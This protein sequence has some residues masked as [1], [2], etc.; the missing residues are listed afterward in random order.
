MKVKRLEREPAEMGLPPDVK[1]V[2]VLLDQAISLQERIR[3]MIEQVTREGKLTES[4]QKEMQDSTS[5]LRA[6]VEEA[7]GARAALQFDKL[8]PWIHQEARRLGARKK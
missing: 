2:L 4:R 5:Q 1:H 3:G 8:K 6:I 7:D